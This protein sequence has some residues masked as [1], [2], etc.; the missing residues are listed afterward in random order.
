MDDQR[1]SGSDDAD[2]DLDTQELIKPA[3]EE[4]LGYGHGEWASAAFTATEE[5]KKAPSGSES[6]LE[7]R[8][9]DAEAAVDTLRATTS[10]LER[11]VS[12]IRADLERLRQES[13]RAAGSKM[14]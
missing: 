13:E 5:A 14:P 11:E 6:D 4:P 9:R 10:S 8:V 3:S 1:H 2:I 7:H 12:E